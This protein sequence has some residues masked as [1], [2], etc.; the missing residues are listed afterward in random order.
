MP[1]KN[2]LDFAKNLVA[3]QIISKI[4]VQ[5][6]LAEVDRLQKTKNAIS[7]ENF[8]LKNGVISQIEVDRMKV[9]QKRVAHCDQCKAMYHIEEKDIGKTFKCKK[10]GAMINF[11]SDASINAE[12]F[13]QEDKQEQN[14]FEQKNESMLPNEAQDIKQS[15]NTMKKKAEIHFDSSN[16]IG[17]STEP[18][19]DSFAQNNIMQQ[20]DLLGSE[21]LATWDNTSDLDSSE[22]LATW[23]NTS[24]LNSSESLATWDNTS[25][26]D[27]YEPSNHI[28]FS[29]SKYD[30]E[31]NSIKPSEASRSY[32]LEDDATYNV[33]LQW[34]HPTTNYN[35][36]VSFPIYLYKGT[37]MN[38]MPLLTI[39]RQL[40]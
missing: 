8:L 38:K 37:E 31:K 7:L 15:I 29:S 23:D 9:P 10:C 3:K 28:L 6:Y 32:S 36:T 27:T 13:D 24:D 18:Q 21:S 4:E 33:Y 5:H 14:I 39:L 1:T 25:N 22:S 35:Y 19:Q 34:K 20:D 11:S 2:D 16:F 26:V 12:N 17:S 30:L 40:Q